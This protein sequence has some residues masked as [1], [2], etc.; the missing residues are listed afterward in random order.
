MVQASWFYMLSHLRGEEGEK[1]PK[2]NYLGLVF[3]FKC[4]LHV[5]FC[6]A[7]HKCLSQTGMGVEVFCG[8]SFYQHRN[9]TISAALALRLV[10]RVS[11]LVF[12]S[13]REGGMGITG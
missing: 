13:L 2:A 6:F 4:K 3:L 7:Q 11:S 5:A 1:N 10:P 12:F 8:R 9:C